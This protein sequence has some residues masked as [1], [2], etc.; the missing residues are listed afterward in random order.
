VINHIDLGPTLFSRFRVLQSLLIKEGITLGGN[1]KLK[2][3]GKLTCGA[4]KRM[5][6]VNRVFFANQQDA[7]QAGYRPCGIC[8]PDEYKLWKQNNDIR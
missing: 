6:P 7:V 2:I 3:Y 4:G 5:K 1:K 8:M